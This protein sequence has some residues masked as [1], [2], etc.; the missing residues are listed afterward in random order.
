MY[1]L[2]EA[3]RALGGLHQVTA[4]RLFADI[5]Q[6]LL[7]PSTNNSTTLL[8][9]SF[10]RFCQPCYHRLAN[11]VDAA[12]VAIRM[13]SDQPTWLFARVDLPDPSRPSACPSSPAVG[14]AEGEMEG[15][16][17]GEGDGKG[18]RKGKGEG[19]GDTEGSED[20]DFRRHPEATR[21]AI[22]A[23]MNANNLEQPELSHQL[24]HATQWYMLRLDLR[25]HM[26][27]MWYR[28]TRH[29]LHIS[30]ALRAVPRVDHPLATK[31]FTFLDMSGA[32]NFGA[33]PL[34]T[35]LISSTDRD[36]RRRVAIVGSGITGLIAARQ[37]HSFGVDVSIFEARDRPGGRINMEKNIFSAPVDLGAMIITGVIQNPASVLAEQTASKM[38]NIDPDCR[39]F[40]VD[41]RWVPRYADYWAE[42]EYNAV[43][44]ATA[45][46]RKKDSSK[47]VNTLSLGLAFQK[48]LLK[49]VQRRRLHYRQL[50][51]KACAPFLD[52]LFR[53]TKPV[54]RISSSRLRLRGRTEKKMMSSSGAGPSTVPG[55]SAVEGDDTT[56]DD[57][58]TVPSPSAGKRSRST[59]DLKIASVGKR[60]R[61]DSGGATTERAL[62]KMQNGKITDSALEKEKNSNPPKSTKTPNANQQMEP[63]M[64]VINP[65]DNDLISRL[66]RWHI[67]N[68][69]YAC[70]SAIDKVSLKHWDQDDPYAFDGDHVLLKKG[71]GPLIDALANG[72]VQD[73]H[74]G[75]EVTGIRRSD[76][77]GYAVIESQPSSEAARRANGGMVS[78]EQFDAV[79][80]TV[81]LGVLKDE[82]IQFEPP[83][84]SFKTNAIKRLGTGGLMKVA[85]E[86]PEQFWID[87]DMFG[88]LRENVEKRGAF[89]CFW[90]LR[91]CIGK[92][93]LLGMVAEPFVQKMEGYSDK[94]IVAEAMSVLRRCYPGAPFPIAHAVTRWS[95]DRYARGAYTHIPVGSSGED[96]DLLAA[97]VEPFL[98][99]AGE[100]TCR[101]NPTTCASGIISGLRE[102]H[103]I[104]EKFGM[105]EGLSALHAA[106]LA[107]SINLTDDVSFHVDSQ[108]GSENE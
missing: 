52:G 95:Q 105:V 24:F 78:R 33:L 49:R 75:T 3:I 104:V 11:A 8:R 36:R 45:R 79:L 58:C 19:E 27:R 85:M 77:W 40:D 86:F 71:F 65:S 94:A 13:Q 66:I 39:L 101:M 67:A 106:S 16:E 72:L 61:N 14:T 60:C 88:A 55:A 83:L 28:D 56:G 9:Y 5:R 69:E 62:Q 108:E 37:L 74:F 35:R 107:N 87:S 21:A 54:I 99:F 4:R 68:L 22:R 25:N 38:Y 18:E 42:R 89:Y 43:L 93:I 90:S 59:A 32:I 100:H 84:P 41:G 50:R 70:A 29:R 81:P 64:D 44:S 97:P 96:Y 63:K 57:R 91:G 103:N 92:P 15:E 30:K 80:I 34:V 2:F 1:I 20:D 12:Y 82:L 98:F 73:I 10:E 51:E 7:V 76:E 46:Y 53:G 47:H 6:M 102:A 23:R 31:V 17:E 48:S 26:L